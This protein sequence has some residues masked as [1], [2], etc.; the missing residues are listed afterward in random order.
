MVVTVTTH[1]N[2]LSNIFRHT[3]HPAVATESALLL[4]PLLLGLIL[5]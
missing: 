5:G 2:K 1:M 4:E 3:N